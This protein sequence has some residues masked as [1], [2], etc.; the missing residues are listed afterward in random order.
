MIDYINNYDDY[1]TITFNTTE[2][3]NL[4]C[5]YCYEINKNPKTLPLEYAIKFIDLIKDLDIKDKIIVDFIG[6]DSLSDVALLDK[7]CTYVQYRFSTMGITDFIFSISTNGTYF[8]FK[9]VQEFVMKWRKVLSL[10][11]SIDGCP[12][13]H[14]LNRVFPDGTGSMEYIIDSLP[15]I[16]ENIPYALKF[17]K[18]T[19]SKQSIPY[20][21]E[22]LKYMHEFLGIQYIHQNFI[23]EPSGITDEDLKLLDQQY[24]LCVDYVYSHRDD[25]YWQLLRKPSESDFDRPFCGSGSMYTLGIDGKIYLCHRWLPFNLNNDIDMSIGNVNEGITRPEIK[26]MILTGSKRCNCTKEEKCLTCEC[27][28]ICNYCIAGCYD[29]FKEFKR[30]THTCEV[31]KLEY[32]WTKYYWELVDGK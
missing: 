14:N 16:R 1:S 11:I 21:F 29:E 20:M 2:D 15:W 32:K 25:L 30:T 23:M 24:K 9:D 28:P 4:R 18:S 8:K 12:D 22:S 17:T 6:G 7:I 31:A 10:G 27:E 5:R 19:L 13:L 26:D 3:C